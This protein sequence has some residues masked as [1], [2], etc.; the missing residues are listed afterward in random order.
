M[1]LEWVQELRRR[2]ILL[3]IHCST[4]YLL[5]HVLIGA[6]SLGEHPMQIHTKV[7]GWPD[8]GDHVLMVARG[9]LD[10]RGLGQI[11]GDIAAMAIRH[12][13]CKALIDLIDAD[14]KVE[15]EEIDRLL[16]EPRPDLWPTERKIALV[17]SSEQHQYAR[18][19]LVR[20]SLVRHGFRVALFRNA[21][22]AVDWLAD[23]A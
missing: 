14:C 4:L 5:R 13:N 21:K 1:S 18:L 9:V 19:C 6:S 2:S 12:V 17:S 23:E 22:A 8:K 3:Q 20:T 10:A 16:H 15:L 7:F 11:L